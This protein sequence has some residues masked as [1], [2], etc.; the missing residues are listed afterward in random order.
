[1]AFITV[2][3]QGA[4]FP[5][6]AAVVTGRM[7]IGH[8]HCQQFP[9]RQHSSITIATVG[10]PGLD[11]TLDHPSHRKVLIT[12]AESPSLVADRSWDRVHGCPFARWI[13][14]EASSAARVL[15]QI[16]HWNGITW[17]MMP[18]VALVAAHHCMTAWVT[19]HPVLAHCGHMLLFSSAAYQVWERHAS[20][21]R[22]RILK[23]GLYCKCFVNTG[24][25]SCFLP[26]DMMT[27]WEWSCELR[28][29]AIVPPVGFSCR[30]YHSS[31][32]WKNC[33]HVASQQII[34][35]HTMTAWCT[36]CVCF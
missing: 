2:C 16:G 27:S 34:Y 8:Q 35:L 30:S 14:V 9:G 4:V 12:S 21:F 6:H 3:F 22:M 13:E 32:C 15:V 31:E 5:P 17:W 11:D 1:M 33:W 26:P 7:S 10:K 18:Q 19:L 36:G 23:W 20:T 28:M 24:C 25:S 29:Q